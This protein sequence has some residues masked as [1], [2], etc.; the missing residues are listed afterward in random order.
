MNFK[1]ELLKNSAECVPS[2]VF[3]VFKVELLKNSAECVPSF[4]FLE[5]ISSQACLDQSGLTDIF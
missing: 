1:V 4:V 2:F 5:K 3:L